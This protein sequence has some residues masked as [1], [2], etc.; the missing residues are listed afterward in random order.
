[1]LMLTSAPPAACCGRS[2]AHDAR[3][4]LGQ[5]EFLD[6]DW[7]RVERELQRMRESGR[8]G[9]HAENMLRDVGAI[10]SRSH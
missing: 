2:H 5:L 10:A 1:M 6:L 8:S 3:D 9:P 4:E 7:E